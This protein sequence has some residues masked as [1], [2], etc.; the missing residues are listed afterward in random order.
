MGSA[1]VLKSR[2]NGSKSCKAN[3]HMH[4]TFDLSED[5]MAVQKGQFKLFGTCIGCISVI[6]DKRIIAC[7]SIASFQGI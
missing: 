3:T 1:L 6:T 2:S 7:R 5:A 4:Q